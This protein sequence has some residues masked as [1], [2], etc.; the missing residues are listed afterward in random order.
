M[1]SPHEQYLK[2]YARV[3][4]LAAVSVIVMSCREDGYDVSVGGP[5]DGAGGHAGQSG[6]GAVAG[7]GATTSAAAGRGNNGGAAGR[8]GFSA[9]TAGRS[10]S[11]AGRGTGAAAAIDSGGNG[12]YGG[13]VAD[14]G[15]FA[16][17]GEGFGGENPAAGGVA[18][19]FGGASASGGS[20]GTAT[21][22]GIGGSTAGTANTRGGA[23][24]SS[25]GTV[26]GGGGKATAGSAGVA[27]AS[28][29]AGS[30][31]CGL[32][33]NPTG[34]RTK[35][36]MLLRDEG[37]AKLAFIDIG[38]ATNSWVT[39]LPREQVTTQNPSPVQGRD[40]Q[41]VG[42]CRVM[43]GTDIGYEEYDI[44]TG[45]KLG[46]VTAFPNT[47]SVQR[48]RNGNTMVVG[49]GTAAAPYQ[50]SV[51]LVL[52]EVN[53][54]AAVVNKYVYPGT[55]DRLVRQTPTG[56][57]LVTNNTRVIEGYTTKAQPTDTTN[58]YSPITFD[59]SKVT[60]CT[61]ANPHVW[62]ALRVPTATAGVTEV[63][64][65]TGFC[66]SLAFFREDGTLR[67]R[68]TGGSASIAGGATAVNPYFFAGFQLLSNGNYLVTNWAGHGTGLFTRGIPVL[69]Y[70]PSGALQWWWG[71]PAYQTLLSSIQAVILLDG[72]DPAKLHVADTNG[73]L[74]PVN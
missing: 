14:G 58:Q 38:T 1:A 50:S 10:M 64:A 21:S 4:L 17:A 22:S 3:A 23:T 51:G 6:N 7:A 59:M 43:V 53:S 12:A 68:I 66:A 44:R 65:S 11:G 16:A 9:G 70:T 74:V 40:M 31:S 33:P 61:S 2:G 27:G 48:L 29:N 41:L 63:V 39:P 18:P 34:D 37:A 20:A 42:G 32:L 72:L 52:V 67:A 47:I 46:E 60:N 73:Q 56:T 5:S 25:G 71:D 35:R 57:F 49:I 19:T 62:Q 8:G 36:R 28:A 45:Q 30:G 54:A 24:S 15:T 69:E 26:P 13:A 55:Y